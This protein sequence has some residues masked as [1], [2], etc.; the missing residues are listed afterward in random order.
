MVSTVKEVEYYYS[1]VADKPG[2]AV[3]SLGSTLVL[4]VLAED[5][6]YAP[7]FG[8]Y[9]HR[10]GDLWLVGGASNSGG[11]VLR[12]FFTDEQIADMTERL[13]PDQPTGMDYY[14]LPTVG[15]RFPINDSTLKP[16]LEPRP[17][18]DV[19]FFQGILEGISQIEKRGYELL[20]QLGAPYPVSLRSVG[21]G[22][23]NRNWTKIRQQRLDIQLLEAGSQEAAYGVALIAMAGSHDRGQQT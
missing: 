6:V 1:L 4:K 20:A 9:S 15:E 8:V 2:E 17:E 14:P 21:G 19:I 7:E 12:K 18:N 16:R 3:T 11:A 10:Y 5:P 22:A 23:I 13:S